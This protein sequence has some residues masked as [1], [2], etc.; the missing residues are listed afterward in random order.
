MRDPSASKRSNALPVAKQPVSFKA[1]KILSSASS[2]EPESLTCTSK[3]TTSPYI[4]TTDA[5][6]TSPP[7]LAKYARYLIMPCIRHHWSVTPVIFDNA[8]QV[9]TRPWKGKIPPESVLSAE[10]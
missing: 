8:I 4:D 3:V 2:I 9:A 10:H 5:A 7:R 6:M 1:A